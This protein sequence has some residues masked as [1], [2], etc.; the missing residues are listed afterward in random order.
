MSLYCKCISPYLCWGGLVHITPFSSGRICTS[1]AIAGIASGLEFLQSV[2]FALASP[3]IVSV[4]FQYNPKNQIT[5]SHQGISFSTMI[6][7]TDIRTTSI[8]V[9]PSYHVADIPLEGL[10]TP[11]SSRVATNSVLANNVSKVSLEFTTPAIRVRLSGS[12][13]FAENSLARESMEHT[14]WVSITFDGR[15]LTLRFFHLAS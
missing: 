2:G 10:G 1:L 15:L 8:G 3:C 9:L 14:M 13:E 7:R 6:L 4:C 11:N 5:K 12:L